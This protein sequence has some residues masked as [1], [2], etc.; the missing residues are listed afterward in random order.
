MALYEAAKDPAHKVYF[1]RR[2]EVHKRRRIERNRKIREKFVSVEHTKEEILKDAGP[3]PDIK[4]PAPRKRLTKD[5][6]PNNPSPDNPKVSK[7]KVSKKKVSK[8]K[9][10]K[11]KVSKKKTTDK[12][13]EE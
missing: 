11:K 8:K 5:R 7:K 4:R 12:K 9:V 13:S 3:D 6:V 1:K 2:A 10:S